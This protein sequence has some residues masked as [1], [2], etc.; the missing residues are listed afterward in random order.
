VQ[1]V[2][3]LVAGLGT[4][5]SVICLGVAGQALYRE[6]VQWQAERRALKA[7]SAWKKVTYTV[8]RRFGFEEIEVPLDHDV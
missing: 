2:I 7:E 1:I 6:F 5:L 8:K 3:P 4:G